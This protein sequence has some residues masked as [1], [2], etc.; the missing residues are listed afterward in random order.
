MVRNKTWKEAHKSERLAQQ[1]RLRRP[2]LFPA[3][4]VKT[5]RRLRAEQQLTDEMS[6]ESDYDSH[7][8]N[9]ARVC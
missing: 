7:P 8:T 3:P 2:C 9:R 5:M 4:T 6:S 1:S